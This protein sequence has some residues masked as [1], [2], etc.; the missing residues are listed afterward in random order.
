[1]LHC[2]GR[3]FEGLL[4][5]TRFIRYE[6]LTRANAAAI[7]V[8]PGRS[9]AHHEEND[10]D[11]SLTQGHHSE[12]AIDDCTRRQPYFPEAHLIIFIFLR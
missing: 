8:L 9:R 7:S 5:A 3:L 2:I 12:L 4:G 6:L 1:M 10:N 11:E